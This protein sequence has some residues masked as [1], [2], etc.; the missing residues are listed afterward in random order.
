MNETLPP[1]PPVQSARTPGS[2]HPPA[3][4][5]QLGG[6]PCFSADSTLAN[7]V[8]EAASSAAELGERLID[9]GDPAMGERVLRAALDLFRLIHP[10]RPPSRGP[11]DSPLALSATSTPLDVAT[12]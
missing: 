12:A 1:H 11:A 9:D 6:E 10:D 7:V 8:G 3:L 2:D 4:G 5:E